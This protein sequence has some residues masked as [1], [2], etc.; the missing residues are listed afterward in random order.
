[1]ILKGFSKSKA[2]KSK[3]NIFLYTYFFLSFSLFVLVILLFMNTGFWKDNK[4]EIIK[5]IHL[6]GIYNYKYLPNIAWLTISNFFTN[7]ETIE[8]NISQKDQ[9]I[10]GPSL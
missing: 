10:L 1:M 6:N 2:K 5:R 4:S 9:I 7:L 3:L 8:L